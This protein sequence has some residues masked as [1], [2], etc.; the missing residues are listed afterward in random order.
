MN[1]RPQLGQRCQTPRLSL[2]G[3]HLTGRVTT[4]PGQDHRADRSLGHSSTGDPHLCDG[5]F[6]APAAFKPLIPSVPSHGRPSGPA[7]PGVNPAP[8]PPRPPGLRAV[9]SLWGRRVPGGPDAAV[10]DQGLVP[11]GAPSSCV[12]GR[13]QTSACRLA[14]PTQAEPLGHSSAHRRGAR[15]LAARPNADQPA[16]ARPLEG[17]ENSRKRCPCSLKDTKLQSVCYCALDPLFPVGPATGP[18][19]PQK[20]HA[21]NPARMTLCPRALTLA[22]VRRVPSRISDTQLVCQAQLPQLTRP[23]AHASITGQNSSEMPRRGT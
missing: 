21:P 11:R 9:Y 13:E 2:L 20:G 22:S 12:E 23:R 16:P 14:G 19:R 7:R 18:T 10:E 8:R 1:A 6:W 3:P 4:V 5:T 17:Q 15:G